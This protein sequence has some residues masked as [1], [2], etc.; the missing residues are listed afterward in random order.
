[1]FGATR[2][3]LGTWASILVSDEVALHCM[4]GKI[5]MIGRLYDKRGANRFFCYDGRAEFGVFSADRR[6]CAKIA[7]LHST[8][9]RPSP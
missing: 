4:T 8:A 7:A 6:F 3:I 2:G 1:M 9:V 5:S